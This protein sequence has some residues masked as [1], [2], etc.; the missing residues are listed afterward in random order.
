VRAIGSPI[1]AAALFSSTRST[2][3]AMINTARPL[4][5]PRKI[6]DFAICATSQPIAAAASAAVR[7]LAS[8]SRT[9][10]RPPSAA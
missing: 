10:N 8:N 5:A 3:E 4:V 6:S 9:S 7:V 1:A 2:P